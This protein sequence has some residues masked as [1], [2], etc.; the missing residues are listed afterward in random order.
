MVS[1]TRR[2]WAALALVGVCSI[3]ANGPG[4]RRALN[5]VV[6][7]LLLAV[8]AAVVA[9]RRTD[10]PSFTRVLPGDGFVGETHSVA[11]E[12]DTDKPLAGVLREDTDDGL[13]TESDDIDAT[14]DDDPVSYEATYER[15][16]VH[17]F[18]PLFLSVTDVLGLAK[19][20][21]EYTDTDSVTA[22]PRVYELA[23]ATRSELSMLAG[24]ALDKEREEFDRLR[25]YD[26]GDS[27][28]DIHWKSSA[29]RAD[30]E[31]VVKEFAAEEEVG[32]VTLSVETDE[33]TA[34]AAAEAAASLAVHFLSMGV[35]V[36]L[37]IPHQRALEPDAGA[38]HRRRLLERFAFLSAGE[39]PPGERDE[40]DVG[41]EGYDGDAV[42]RID[43]HETNFDSL[44][45]LGISGSS[46]VD[47]IEND[48][49]PPEV[50]P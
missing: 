22:Y 31:L 42:V 1:L 27:L 4:G 25:E 36:G 32:D 43:D 40:A 12:F 49:A 30:D 16:G 28:R 34:D 50:V 2:G 17:E 19:T 23:G 10:R 20:S 21:F 38:D 18:G 48:A 33:S 44:A 46:G 14:I 6:V 37:R 5:A 45:G 7:P 39:L 11:L 26:S 15:R 29:K 24:S 13:A 3:L 8:I 35:S 41:V 9:V 47:P